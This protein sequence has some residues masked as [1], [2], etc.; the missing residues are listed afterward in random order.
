M[1][2]KE[3]QNFIGV[4]EGIIGQIAIVEGKS[5]KKAESSEILISPQD[6]EIKLEAIF[7]SGRD[8]FCLILCE[9]QKLERG[10]R[11]IGTGECLRVPV[12]R[13]ILGRVIDLFGKPLDQKEEELPSLSFSI[14]SSPP[15]ISVLETS[16]NILETGIKALD[17]LTPILEG[18]K[19]GIVGGA[20]VGKTVLMTELLHNLI[21]KHKG[22]GVFTGVGERIREGHELYKKLSEMGVLSKIAIVLGQMNENAAIRFRS[23]LAGV[24]IAEYFRDEEKEDVLFFMD[25]IFRYIQAGGEISSLLGLP[26]SEQGYQATLQSEISEIQDR[27]VSTKNGKITSF[28]TVYVPADDLTDVAV[29][30]ILSSLDT[31][32]VLSREA[33]SLGF[34]PPIDMDLSSSSAISMKIISKEHFETLTEFRSYFERYRKLSHIIAIVGEAELSLEDQLVYRRT[35]KVINYLTQNLFTVE[36]QTGKKGVYVPFKET[37]RDIRLIL[38]G[39]LDDVPQEKLLYISSFK[40]SG[41]I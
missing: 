29:S 17:F 33:A 36:A 21:G 9:S 3:S 28:Q 34:Y 37:L 16:R 13:K 19:I 14:Y 31:A 5:S 26:L 39:K 10:M 23:A 25:N 7:H 2:D 11:V 4:I 38:S 22:V 6:P 41:I 24:T 18:S 35:Q 32:I 15:P 27:L 1:E 8:V 40:E 30:S 20:G 12:G